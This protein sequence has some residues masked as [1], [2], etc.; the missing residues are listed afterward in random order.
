MIEPLVE[1]MVAWTNY[2]RQVAQPSVEEFCRY[3][4]ESGYSKIKLSTIEIQGKLIRAIG[5]IASAYGLY[6][7]A[8]M[9]EM[10]LPGHESFYYLNGLN[11]IGDGKK[12]D[13][14]NYLMAETTTGMDAI[15][16]LIRAGLI[17]ERTDAED[18]RA[19]YIRLTAKGKRKLADCYALSA[20]VNEMIFHGIPDQ[21][22]SMCAKLLSAIEEEHS[23]KA[24]ALK[25]RDFKEMYGEVTSAI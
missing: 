22:I 11:T 16:K 7:K 23:K 14:I 21:V 15:Q 25:G 13:L 19:K 5:R 12:M 10:G 17:S 1:L 20:K 18:R 9:T 2:S 4:I 8:A 3:T 6:H 24:V